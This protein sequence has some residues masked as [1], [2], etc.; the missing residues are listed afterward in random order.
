M[1]QRDT[2]RASIVATT[3]VGMDHATLDKLSQLT[4]ESHMETV[5]ADLAIMSPKARE[6]D[7]EAELCL[8]DFEMGVTLG[9]GSFGRVRLARYRRTGKHYAIKMMN[10]AAVLQ[11]KQLEHI[12]SEKNIL[13]QIAYPFVVNMFGTFQDETTIY[14]VFEFVCGGEFFTLL[15]N[16]DKL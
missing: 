14:M 7:E 4:E 8:G 1:N 9:L 6:F 2:R 13:V 10:K 12:R 5:D 3:D 15:R 16:E 11:M